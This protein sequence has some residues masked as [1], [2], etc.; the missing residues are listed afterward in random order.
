ML[1]C[2]LQSRATYINFWT[3][4]RTAYN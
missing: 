3:H 4:F 2:D 1:K